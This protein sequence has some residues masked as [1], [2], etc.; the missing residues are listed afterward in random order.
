MIKERC[1]ICDEYTG[2]AGRNEDSDV[3]DIC[4]KVICEECIKLTLK[5]NGCS[6]ICKECYDKMIEGE[7]NE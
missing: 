4:N 3:C 2:N 7:D 6:I 5:I 1:E